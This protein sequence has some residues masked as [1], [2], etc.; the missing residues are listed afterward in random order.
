MVSTFLASSPIWLS[1]ACGQ[2][3]VSSG[4]KGIPNRR[5]RRASRPTLDAFFT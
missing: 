4:A 3:R 2:E 5:E 1:V